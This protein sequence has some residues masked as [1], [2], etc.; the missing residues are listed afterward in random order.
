VEPAAAPAAQLTGNFMIG[1][2]IELVSEAMTLL[3]KSGVR[4]EVRCHTARLPHHMVEAW[5]ST[6][7]PPRSHTRIL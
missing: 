1:G 6:R 7:C 5:P 4:R 3:E 2:V